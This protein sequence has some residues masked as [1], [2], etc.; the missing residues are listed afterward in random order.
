MWSLKYWHQ[1]ARMGKVV[2]KR[3]YMALYKSRNV[4]F[5]RIETFSNTEGPW[6][7]LPELTVTLLNY[8]GF[9]VCN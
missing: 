8:V 1:L 9:S 4:S 6:A 7:E 3:I 2:R 5:V